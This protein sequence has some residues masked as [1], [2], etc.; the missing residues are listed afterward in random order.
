MARLVGKAYGT[1][2]QQVKEVKS[3]VGAR[4]EQCL[5]VSD[6]SVTEV[7]SVNG[8][9]PLFLTICA[10]VRVRV[11][12]TGLPRVGRERDHL[13]ERHR[14]SITR[15]RAPTTPPHASADSH[16]HQLGLYLSGMQGF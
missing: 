16:D 11:G 12:G 5:A 3:D 10:R 15:P 14:R 8:T 6:W 9:H 7:E 13:T 4:L 2:K 1:S